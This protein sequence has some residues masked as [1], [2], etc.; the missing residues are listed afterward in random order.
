MNNEGSMQNYKR[1]IRH[2]NFDYTTG[3]GL[4]LRSDN[5]FCFL[6]LRR[7]EDNKTE[8]VHDIS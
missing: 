6:G 5:S 8:L 2:A 7:P 4:H 3:L 1:E